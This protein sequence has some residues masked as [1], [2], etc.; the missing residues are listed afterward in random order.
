[1]RTRSLL[2]FFSLT[3]RLCAYRAA[4]TF[5]A[6]RTTLTRC[7]H[8]RLPARRP[9]LKCAPQAGFGKKTVQAKP[10]EWSGSNAV[11]VQ[12]DHFIQARKHKELLWNL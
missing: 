3:M 7:A 8:A 5:G 9:P 6:A 4:D 2:S 1:M 11:K 12:A 10:A